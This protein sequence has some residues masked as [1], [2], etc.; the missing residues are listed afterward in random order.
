MCY[1][2]Y[3]C[4]CPS[5]DCGEVTFYDGQWIDRSE[6]NC[7][8]GRNICSDDSPTHDSDFPAL[9]DNTE[10]FPYRRLCGT[11]FEQIAKCDQLDPPIQEYTCDICNEGAIYA[12][13][14]ACEEHIRREHADYEGAL[15]ARPTVW[16][17]DV[18][19]RVSSKT[20]LVRVWGLVV[21]SG[22]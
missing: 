22:Y 13:F 15:R 6:R 19:H 4:V 2:A 3:K 17:R 7:G 11:H 12:T 14:D 9:L 18:K 8:L 10:N 21:N 16:V 20:D 1:W 5:P